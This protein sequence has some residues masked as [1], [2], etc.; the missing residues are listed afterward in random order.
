MK[1]IKL[2]L[3]S[4]LFLFLAAVAV[5]LMIPSRVRISRAVDLQDARLAMQMVHDTSQWDQWHPAFMHDS[6]EPPAVSIVSQTDTSMIV[7]MHRGNRKPFTS[8][9][10]LHRYPHTD[11]VTLQWYMDFQLKWYPWE[12]FSS[13]FFEN[14]FGTLMEEG[15][16]N[17]KDPNRVRTK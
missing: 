2:G 10:L 14:V 12:K 7:T 1:I 11:T 9:W 16:A 6:L 3:I 5:S 8:G 4:V 17:L 15:L 13:L